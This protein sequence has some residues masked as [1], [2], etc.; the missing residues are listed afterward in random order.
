MKVTYNITVDYSS[1]PDAENEDYVERHRCSDALIAAIPKP[2]QT[3][4]N[5]VNVKIIEHEEMT[6]S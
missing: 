6:F 4:I 1:D 3:T 5:E 2:M